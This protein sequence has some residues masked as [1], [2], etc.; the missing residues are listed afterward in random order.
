MAASYTRVPKKV[1]FTGSVNL[2]IPFRFNYVR[3]VGKTA[4][5]INIDIIS[6]KITKIDSS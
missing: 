1:Y 5:L 2:T 4:I 6:I 3:D